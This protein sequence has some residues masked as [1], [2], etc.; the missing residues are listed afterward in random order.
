MLHDIL[1]KSFLDI[2]SVS[3]TDSQF[4]LMITQNDYFTTALLLFNNESLGNCIF[5]I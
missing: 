1:V 3:N 5:Y 4:I 2:R